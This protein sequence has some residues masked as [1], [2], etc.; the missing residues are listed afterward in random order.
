MKVLLLAAALICLANGDSQELKHYYDYT[1]YYSPDY[2][3]YYTYYYYYYSPDY[4]YYYYTPGYTYY[5]DPSTYYDYL[6]YKNKQ[7]MEETFREVL[8][9]F[10]VTV[11]LPMLCC[12]GSIGL[13]VYIT[14]KFFRRD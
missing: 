13:C 5:Y 8:Y 9:G 2:S 12:G 7:Q 10:F 3:T 14:W 1:Y 6:Y 4:S 11:F